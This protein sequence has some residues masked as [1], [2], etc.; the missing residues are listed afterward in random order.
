M[1]LC[2]L[3]FLVSTFHFTWQS[4]KIG[5]TSQIIKSLDLSIVATQNTTGHWITTLLMDKEFEK[6]PNKWKIDMKQVITDNSG[7]KMRVFMKYTVQP[8]LPTDYEVFHGVG[9]Y[10]FH[11]EVA[12][13]FRDATAVCAK[14]GGHLAIIN[15]EAEAD[16]LKTLFNRYPE[17]K[18]G[19]LS[20]YIGFYK[21]IED[22]NFYTIFA[23]PISSTGFMRWASPAEPNNLDNNENC[24]SVMRNGGLN[25]VPCDIDLPFICEYDISWVIV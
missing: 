13:S 12:H 4:E 9:Y 24:G 3:I 23:L 25:D 17:N 14:E 5:N 11:I 1:D 18:Y 10:K 21:K 16:V 8:P 20:A 6:R 22:G 7:L 2:F 15:S 19:F